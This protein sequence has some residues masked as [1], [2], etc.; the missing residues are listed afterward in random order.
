MPPCPSIARVYMPDTPFSL[1]KI[2]VS[3]F[4][5]SVLYGVANGAIL[6]VIA[7]TARELGATVA[8]SGLIV[9]LIGVGSLVSNVPAAL[10]TS[11]VGE[12]RA[13]VGA[14]LFSALALLMCIFAVHLWMLATGVLM[15]GMGSSVF[16]LARQAYLIEAV[17][18]EMR[19]RALSTLAGTMR[20]GVFIGPF[21]GAAM[22]YLMGLSGAYWVAVL[23]M[24]AAAW[25]ALT[26]PELVTRTR[27]AS[28]G[29]TSAPP[30]LLDIMR[31]HARVFATLGLG[32]LLVSALRGSRQVVIPLWADHLGLDPAAASLVYGLSAAIDMAVFYPAGKVMD[33]HGR[34]WVALPC[35][36]L[37]GLSLLIMPLAS[38]VPAFLAVSLAIG[39]GNGIGSGIIMTLGAD[40]SPPAGRHAFLG[41]WRMLADVGTGGGPLLLSA[42]TAMASLSAAI[43]ATGMLG[44]IAAGVF[45]RWIPRKE[46]ALK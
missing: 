17:P 27:S 26:L 46:K 45:W 42:V 40:A 9:A 33:E 8:M 32:A 38:G 13:I 29:Q 30:R 7:L 21:A 1:K 12:K 19:A 14:A 24:F 25:L 22:I 10:I 31:S 44:L 28:P 36:L 37:M 15:V 18:V 35:T 39:L 5:P 20:I 41:I 23:A 2:A 3:A 6:P 11:R 43:A 34:I 16:A 4:G